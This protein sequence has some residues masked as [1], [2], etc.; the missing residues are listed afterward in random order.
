MARKDNITISKKK[1]LLFV[2]IVI[3]FCLLLLAYNIL[4]PGTPAPGT[5]PPSPGTT[6]PSPGTTPP[7][8]GT[9]PPSP[10]TTPPSP[11]TTPP[12]PP[13][14][15]SFN[16]TVSTNEG[17]KACMLN[18]GC[19]WSFDVW[20]GTSRP[21][22]QCRPRS[23]D[24]PIRKHDGTTVD[25]CDFF[26]NGQKESHNYCNANAGRCWWDQTSKTC[27]TRCN[28]ASGTT[29]PMCEAFSN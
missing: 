16:C 20:G 10:G 19:M 7:S 17:A 14:P 11:G 18:T 15:P 12:T 23:I 5:T 24:Q 25:S 28:D 29:P 26:N 13:A 27:K 6:P 9:T 1:L 2:A 4:K 3:I 22:G 21:D 8:P